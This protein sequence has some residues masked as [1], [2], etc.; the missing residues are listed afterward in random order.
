MD[1]E[2]Q[3]PRWLDGLNKTLGSAANYWNISML[4]L[5]R[6]LLP[7]GKTVCK[8]SKTWI[9][10]VSE[11]K[12]TIMNTPAGAADLFGIIIWNPFKLFSS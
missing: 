12:M 3:N 7:Q 1:K 5:G 9:A 2:L 6:W 4:I 11:S 10:N 8:T